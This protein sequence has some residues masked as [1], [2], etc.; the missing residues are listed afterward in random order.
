MI[1]RHESDHQ[2]IIA[3]GEE[4]ERG[5]EYSHQHGAKISET[6]KKAEDGTNKFDQGLV[7]DSLGLLYRKS[8]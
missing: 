5:I 8:E 1:A 2:Q 7:F 6:Q 4:E 3:E